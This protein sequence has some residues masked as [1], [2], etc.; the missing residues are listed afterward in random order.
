MLEKLLVA[1]YLDYEKIIIDNSS[2]INL[3]PEEAFVFIKVINNYLK[4]KKI[5]ISEMEHETGLTKN[6]LQAILSKLMEN[7][8]YE[9]YLAYTDGIADEYIS[10]TP[11]LNKVEEILSATPKDTD[12]NY[13]IPEVIKL[14]E[15]KINRT[16]TALELDSIQE[17]VLD[18][19]YD[20]S[21]FK[22]AIN[23]CEKKRRI[24]N[25]K[26]LSMMFAYIDNPGLSEAKEEKKTVEEKDINSIFNKMG[27]K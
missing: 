27:R 3:N 26:N 7:S 17:F 4:D 22:A 20:L 1:G 10:L 14:V 16:L 11:F 19:K 8:F 12:R 24:I 2:K 25:I 21:D 5:H 6:K 15:S 23:L 9:I 13:L 18:D